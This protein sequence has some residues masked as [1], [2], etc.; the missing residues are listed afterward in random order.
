MK[1]NG[2]GESTSNHDFT[3]I[4]Q[5]IDNFRQAVA[6]E[7]DGHENRISEYGVLRLTGG[8]DCRDLKLGRVGHLRL[9]KKI[10]VALYYS[11]G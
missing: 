7:T 11:Q 10:K 6:L 2:T 9:Q 3:Q 8:E 1:S 4:Q 5:V